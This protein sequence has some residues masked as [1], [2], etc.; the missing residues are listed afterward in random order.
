MLYQYYP[1]IKQPKVATFGNNNNKK[2]MQ[3]NLGTFGLQQQ[4]NYTILPAS[5]NHIHVSTTSSVD[6]RNMSKANNAKL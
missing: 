5:T 4:Q 1:Y 6:N 3:K 2:N